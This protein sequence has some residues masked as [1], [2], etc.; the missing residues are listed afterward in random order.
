MNI[1]SQIKK[2]LLLKFPQY[3]AFGKIVDNSDEIESIAIILLEES[4]S[5]QEL[6]LH[7]RQWLNDYSYDKDKKLIRNARNLLESRL[8]PAS[9]IIQNHLGSCGAL[10]TLGASVLRTL[11]FPVK[12]VHGY[13]EPDSIDHAWVEVYLPVAS[14]WLAFDFTGKG[15]KATGNIS[16]RHHKIA[17]CADW[18]EIKDILETQH[19][20]NTIDKSK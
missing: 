5:E 14:N 1:S 19:K 3:L 8:T 4:K 15:D 20:R 7:L 10:V 13:L 9:T 2:R 18:S 6:L 11:G 12:L 17:E 16:R